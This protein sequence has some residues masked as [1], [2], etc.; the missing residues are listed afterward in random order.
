MKIELA[1]IE[2]SPLLPPSS[3]EYTLE[4]FMKNISSYDSIFSSKLSQAAQEHRS[5]F[6]GATIDCQAKSITVGLIAVDRNHPFCS[7]SVA[8]NII[9]FTTERYKEQ[10][11]VIKGPGAGAQVTAAGVFADII[12]AVR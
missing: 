2:M 6:F 12:R 11:L 9:A 4:E 8:D 3:S 7:L 5:L 10:P 1:D